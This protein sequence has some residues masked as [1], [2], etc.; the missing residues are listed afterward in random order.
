MSF[1]N[2]KFYGTEGQIK[3][4]FLSKNY[5]FIFGCARSSLLHGL[6]FSCSKLELLFSALKLT[7]P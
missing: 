2:S 6:F 7:V 5:L 1:F 4:A 3:H